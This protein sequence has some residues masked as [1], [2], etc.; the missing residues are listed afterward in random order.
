M[1]HIEAK[2]R[3]KKKTIIVIELNLFSMNFETP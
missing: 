2:R 1:D 3:Q